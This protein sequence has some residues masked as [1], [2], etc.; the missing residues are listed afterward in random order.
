MSESLK[1]TF[2]SHA[3]LRIEGKFGS[4]VC[5]PWI[6]NEPVYNFTTWKFPAAVMP[7]E[8]VYR[9]L[10]YVYFSHP[11]EDHFHIPSIDLIPRDT[12]ILLAEYTCKPGLRAQTM[13]RTLREMG[14][15]NIKKIKPWQSLDLGEGSVFTLLPACET[16]WWDWE[17]SGFVLEQDNYK[18]LNM[19]DCPS[20]KALYE[21]VD[22]QFGQIDIA[23]I[24]YA[25]VSMFPGCYRMPIE[26]MK[27][28][29]KERR[30]SWIQQRNV[31]EY[32]DI[33]RI[34]PFAGDFAWLSDRMWHCNW[35]N[36]ATPLEFKEYV[37]THE[38]GGGVELVLMYPSDEWTPES[39][40]TKN[41][42]PIDWSHYLDHIKEV[43]A[44]YQSK[45][46]QLE[47]WIDS[48][49]LDDLE[50]R[51]R[52]HIAYLQQWIYQEDIVFDVRVRFVVEWNQK[53]FNFV[54][55]SSV[56]EGVRFLWDD[57]DEVDQTLYINEFIWAAVVEGK[58]L[59]NNLQW[60]AENNQHV[61]FRL[62][63][64]HFWF[65]FETHIDLNNR[66]SQALVDS[67]LHPQLSKRLRPEH[68]VFTQ[69]N[70][71]QLPWLNRH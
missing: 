40:I 68:G 4:L 49:S 36:R 5:D 14:F 42:P 61:P 39:G 19:N 15:Y 46:S 62:E 56:E 53:H 20:D 9:Q 12:C 11:H 70:E 27:A 50:Q 71:W 13:E 54:I 47:Q 3:C 45:I 22:K 21:Q 38:R 28:A 6:L 52:T 1:V 67:V 65:W 64:A 25:G 2:V 17:N 34:A 30:T 63:I 29:V 57:S 31:L 10:D 16:K 69:P 37:E 43:K 7:P 26:E 60:A 32:L 51:T 18:L 24:Q 33:K 41:H 58:M 66:N 59:M 44:H 55:D 8:E 35:S 23:F 48:S